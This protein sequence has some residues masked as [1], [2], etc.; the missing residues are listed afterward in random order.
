MTFTFTNVA[1]FACTMFFG[2]GYSRTPVFYVAPAAPGNDRWGWD[3]AMCGPG[4]TIVHAD[5]TELWA[6]GHQETSTATWD[7]TVHYG[8]GGEPTAQS[9]STDPYPPGAY[10]ATAAF[11]GTVHTNFDEMVIS[12]PVAYTVDPVVTTAPP[13]T[14]TTSTTP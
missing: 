4:P 6:A 8:P 2:R 11:H 1:G 14:S 12:D 10:R 7:A 9:C 5:V 3:T 13:S